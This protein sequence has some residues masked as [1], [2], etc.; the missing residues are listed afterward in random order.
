MA[1]HGLVGLED[2]A[3]PGSCRRQFKFGKSYSSQAVEDVLRLERAVVGVTGEIPV[4]V[5]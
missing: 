5:I 2:R 3:S 4:K 1:D